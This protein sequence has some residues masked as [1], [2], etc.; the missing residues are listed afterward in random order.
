MSFGLDSEHSDII[1]GSRLKAAASVL[2]AAPVLFVHGDDPTLVAGNWAMA[3]LGGGLALMRMII[4]GR[5]VLDERG[6]SWRT[7]FSGGRLAWSEIAYAATGSSYRR[8][9]RTYLELAD[10]DGSPALRRVWIPGSWTISQSALADRINAARER[11]IPNLTRQYA[12]MMDEGSYDRL[13]VMPAMPAIPTA[14]VAPA[15]RETP[16]TRPVPAPVSRPAA[17]VFGRRR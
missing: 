1:Q 10:A 7:M 17:P 16:V 4:P 9:S 2:L 6:L 13:P 15:S 3:V 11:V 14:S 5:I 12:R 8:W